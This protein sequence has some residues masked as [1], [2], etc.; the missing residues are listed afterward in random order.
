MTP[1]WTD[2]E[3]LITPLGEKIKL[4]LPFNSRVLRRLHGTKCE[5]SWD[6]MTE[7]LQQGNHNNIVRKC[8]PLGKT[9]KV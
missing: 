3:G 4:K 8:L 5:Y 2:R 9:R 1:H 6:P 7:E